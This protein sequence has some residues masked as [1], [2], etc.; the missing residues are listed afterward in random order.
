MKQNEFGNLENWQSLADSLTN[1]I[2]SLSNDGHMYVRSDPK[3]VK[4][5][6]EAES[7]ASIKVGNQ[8]TKDPFY[9][10]KDAVQKNFGFSEV[11]VLKD[12]I[13][14]IKLSQINISEKSLPTLYAA[15][16]FVGHTKALIIDLRDNR[17][18]GSDVGPVLESFF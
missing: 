9:Y 16:Q 6:I 11:K 1:T 10:G 15:M 7:K 5:L 4:E 2:Q 17:G 14:Y 12:N 8:P 3:T 13:G 18:G